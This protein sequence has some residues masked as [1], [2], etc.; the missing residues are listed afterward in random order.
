MQSVG[1]LGN[2]S[3]ALQSAFDRFTLW[4]I[5]I[6]GVFFTLSFLCTVWAVVVTSR[7]TARAPG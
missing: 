6:R 3:V 4:G 1:S 2:D 5:Y 7:D